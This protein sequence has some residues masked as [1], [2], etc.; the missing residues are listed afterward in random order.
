MFSL[1]WRDLESK[2]T[3]YTQLS[4]DAVTLCPKPTVSATGAIKMI[5]ALRPTRTSTT[6]E[7]DIF[8]RWAE[9]IAYGARYRLHETPD[10]P[11]TDEAMAQKYLAFFRAAIGEAKIERNRGLTRAVMRVRPPRFY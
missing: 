9:A 8:E 1:D 7:S 6:I 3:Y 10:Q 4:R 2:P 5:V 11:Y